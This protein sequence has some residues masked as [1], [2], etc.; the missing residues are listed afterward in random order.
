VTLHGKVV[1][2][3][4]GSRGIGRACVLDAARRGARVLFCSRTDGADSREVEAAARGGGRGEALGVAADV[5]DEAGVTGLFAVARERYGRIDGVVSNAA[6]SREQMLVT[7]PTEAWD[8]VMATNLTGAFLVVRR[9]VLVFLEQG[10]GGRLV[11]IGTLSQH[12]AAGNTSYAASKGGVAGLIRSVARDYGPR[13]IAANVVV[14][15]YVETA[16]SAGLPE[17]SKRALIEGCPLRRPASADEIAT[18]V[19]FLL[20]DESA[21]LEDQVIFAT[22][23]LLEVPR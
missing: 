9:A 22:G 16:L 7:M 19:S 23:G 5:A 15:G 17:S 13:G 6:I 1:I 2:V 21:G 20:S 4:G 11:A 3:T 10:S 8:A 18:I 12:G 14:P